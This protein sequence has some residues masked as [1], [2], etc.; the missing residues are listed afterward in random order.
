LSVVIC[1]ETPGI[2]PA[3]DN[4]Q[5]TTDNPQ[6][7]EL[8]LDE[9]EALRLVE[10]A[11][12]RAGGGRYIVGSPRHPF[13]LRATQD[14]EVEGHVVTIHF[15]EISSPA[16][17]MLEGWVFEVREDELVLLSRPRQKPAP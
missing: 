8:V 17:A 9:A 14:E 12:E 11:V 1:Q 6:R 7:R 16:I 3:P 13:A 4:R 2:V 15:S 10:I 5:P